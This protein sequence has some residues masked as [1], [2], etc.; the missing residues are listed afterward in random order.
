M[1]LHSTTDLWHLIFN[2]LALWMFGGEVERI[3]G[4]R[5]FFGTLLYGGYFSGICCCIF[6][7]HIP[8]IGA[9]GAILAVEM[10]FALFFPIARLSFTFSP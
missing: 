4:S 1:F 9:S 5:R 10:A 2:M 7:P 3:L 6:T 8:I